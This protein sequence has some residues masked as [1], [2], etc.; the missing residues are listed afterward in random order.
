MSVSYSVTM[1]E[2]QMAQVAKGSLATVPRTPRSGCDVLLR[3]GPVPTSP[4]RTVPH[5][6]SCRRR[7]LGQVAHSPAKLTRVHLPS[8]S[9]SAHLKGS[10]NPKADKHH[11]PG[12]YIPVQDKKPAGN[13]LWEAP[14]HSSS[15][16]LEKA[17]LRE[18]VHFGQLPR[19][20]QGDLSS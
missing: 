7:P 19:N 17:N 13:R 18:E 9:R 5:S 20:L 1:Q 6:A 8:S 11:L 15:Q 12:H 3:E 16:N 10:L 14:G 4:S 2:A